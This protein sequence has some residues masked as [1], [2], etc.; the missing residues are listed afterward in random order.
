MQ[1]KWF[2]GYRYF[3]VK[4]TTYHITSHIA[5]RNDDCDDDDDHHHHHHDDENDDDGKYQ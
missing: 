5:L 2:G 1:N 3:Y 4:R